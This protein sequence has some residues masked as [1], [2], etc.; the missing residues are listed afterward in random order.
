MFIENFHLAASIIPANI[1]WWRKLKPL[2]RFIAD[3]R[4]SFIFG[5]RARNCIFSFVYGQEVT[6]APPPEVV[7]D[8]ISIKWK[9]LIT[10]SNVPHFCLC[11]CFL[12]SFG[13][14]SRIEILYLSATAL[15]LSILW[16]HHINW[17]VITAFLESWL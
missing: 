3:I 12:R 2:V 7:M 13:T 17:T 8:F 16:E 6:T 4:V 5:L 14:S 1:I 15:I 9:T 10:Y 11:N